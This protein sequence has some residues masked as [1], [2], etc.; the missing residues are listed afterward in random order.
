[1][2]IPAA[3]IRARGDEPQR[4]EVPGVNP[5][6]FFLLLP[7]TEA[8][9]LRI[10]Q[11]HGICRACGGQGFY[12]TRQYAPQPA[13]G[14]EEGPKTAIEKLVDLSRGSIV[15]CKPCPTCGHVDP[16]KRVTKDDQAVLKET[17]E[18]VV[19]GAEGVK[20]FNPDGSEAGLLVFSPTFLDD[21]SHCP[22]EA[23]AVLKEAEDLCTITML[24]EVK[25]SAS[26]PSATSAS[27]ETGIE[28]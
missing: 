13:A 22:V 12:S 7:L 1:M 8:I 21:L 26:L 28:G 25:A 4:R 11:K 10:M 14:P 19:K 16:S 9:R 24:A 3:I 5:G 17:L 2:P 20:S 23:K 15:V 18:A 27:D 6:A